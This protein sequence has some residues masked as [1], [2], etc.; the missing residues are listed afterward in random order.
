MTNYGI[1]FILLLIGTSA[2]SL[3]ESSPTDMLNIGIYIVSLWN[4]AIVTSTAIN[5][6]AVDVKK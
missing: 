1:H 5:A 2:T 3:D 6:I 4:K